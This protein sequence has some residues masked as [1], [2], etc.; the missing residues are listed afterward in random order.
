L[1]RV[2][3]AAAVSGEA[4]QGLQQA[5]AALGLSELADDVSAQ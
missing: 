5:L 2:P 3:A 1:A 4:R